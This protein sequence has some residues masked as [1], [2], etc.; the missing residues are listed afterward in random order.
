MTVEA[1]L[2]TQHAVP[3]VDEA[4]PSGSIVFRSIKDVVPR[5]KE[6]VR[7]PS[8]E[9]ARQ[10]KEARRPGPGDLAHT[11]GAR[12]GDERRPRRRRPVP[13]PGQF[14]GIEGMGPCKVA[15]QLRCNSLSHNYGT[16]PPTGPTLLRQAVVGRALLAWFENATNATLVLPTCRDIEESRSASWPRTPQRPRRQ[17]QP[18]AVRRMGHRAE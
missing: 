1:N 9:R 5:P 11:R 6:G 2:K 18:A 15:L 16:C 10:Q 4:D 17:S 14:E 12:R 7:A 3:E 8:G 13:S